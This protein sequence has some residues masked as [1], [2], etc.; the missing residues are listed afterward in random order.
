MEMA[1]WEGRFN[2]SFLMTLFVVQSTLSFAQN[3]T[4][5]GVVVDEKDEPIIGANVTVK[6]TAKGTITDLDGKFVLSAPPKSAKL[7]EV[8]FIGYNTQTVTITDKTLQI[9]LSESAIALDEVVAIGYGSAK[10]GNVTGAIAKVNAEKLEDRAS[11]NIASSL[12]GQLA[13]VEVRSTTGEPGSELQI[14]VRGAASINAD[15]TPLYVVDG[16]PV[17]DLGSLNPGDI[18]SIEVLKR[19]FLIGY[20]WF[21][22]CQ[23]GCLDYHQT[24]RY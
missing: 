24:S 13:G 10:K 14:R 9:K 22:R 18:Q 8:S 7:L 11:T 23:W 5:T 2:I 16:I 6:G 19:C 4:V 12:Q 17:D 20:L 21:P 1:V 3:R 15:A